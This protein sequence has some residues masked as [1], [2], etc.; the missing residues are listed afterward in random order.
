MATKV[1]TSNDETAVPQDVLDRESVLP[2]TTALRT[3]V[4][5]AQYRSFSRTAEELG[6]TQG[7]VSRAVKSIETLTGCRLFERNARGLVLTQAGSVYLEQIKGLLNDLGTATFQLSNYDPSS[8]S[9]HIAVLPSLG[10]LWLA[11]RLVKFTSRFPNIVLMV[12]ANIGIVD[13]IQSDIDCVIHYG[14][15]AWPTGARSE[16]LM[17]E[18]LLPVCSPKLLP[19]R[20]TPNATLLLD[21]PLIQHTHRPTAWREW[22]KEVGIL[23]PAPTSG[24]RFEQY[25]MGIQA[26]IAGMGAALMPPFLV[27]QE[28]ASDKLIAM[29]NSSVLSAWQYHLVYP[30][31]KRNNPNLQKFRSWLLNEARN[32]SIT[33]SRTREERA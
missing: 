3:F 25:Q 10:S 21:M 19:S 16:L 32:S 8:Q 30:D 7:G 28:I 1:R 27:A 2:S 24:N 14:T 17:H 11:P 5:A 15:E 29:H 18:T 9:L 26:A 22:F 4:L 31:A 6:I 12:T 23:H 13:F 33:P 20:T